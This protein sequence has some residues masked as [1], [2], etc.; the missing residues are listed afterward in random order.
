MK[1]LIWK[2]RFKNGVYTVEYRMWFVWIFC[3]ILSPL[4]VVLWLFKKLY[5]AFWSPFHVNEK[6]I[7]AY[8]QSKEYKRAIFKELLKR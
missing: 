7:Y 4:I 6:Q 1:K 5:D 8:N 2:L 3:I